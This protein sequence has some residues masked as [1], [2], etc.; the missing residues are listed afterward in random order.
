[1][2]LR[3]GSCCY[4]RFKGDKAYR[5][6]FPSTIEGSRLIRMGAYNGDYSGGTIVDPN[7]IE[8]Q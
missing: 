5:F 8:I 2:I 7:D 1:M 6:G 4:W 3:I